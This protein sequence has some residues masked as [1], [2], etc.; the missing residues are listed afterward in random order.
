MKDETTPQTREDDPEAEFK[1]LE[2]RTRI[3][4]ARA[5]CRAAEEYAATL[6]GKKKK[7][8]RVRHERQIRP[9]K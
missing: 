6:S 4:L 1:Q 8:Q 9:T 3:A 5:V 2:E 7:R